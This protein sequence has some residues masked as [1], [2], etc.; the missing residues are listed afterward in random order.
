MDH[1][2]LSYLKHLPGNTPNR[3]TASLKHNQTIRKQPHIDQRWLT[4]YCQDKG[5]TL[6]QEDVKAKW[7]SSNGASENEGSQVD[8]SYCSFHSEPDSM[9]IEVQKVESRGVKPFPLPEWDDWLNRVGILAEMD[10]AEALVFPQGSLRW[11]KPLLPIITIGAKESSGVQQA[12][13]KDWNFSIWD[14]PL[15]TNL[16]AF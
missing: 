15:R 9:P 16:T 2:I 10:T 1:Q 11:G 8:S 13:P 4:N 6:S 5:R 14:Q 3:Y 7:S 12:H